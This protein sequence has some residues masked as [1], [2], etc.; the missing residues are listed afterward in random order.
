[1]IIEDP[2]DELYK[3]FNLN[4]SSNSESLS[5]NILDFGADLTGNLDSS[6]A[7][8][9]VIDKCKS[10]NDI[11]DCDDILVK[12]IEI[13][14]GI[15]K[16]NKTIEI[17]HIDNLKFSPII[18]LKDP[19]T[20]STIICDSKNLIFLKINKEALFSKIHIENLI[21]ESIKSIV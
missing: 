3:I 17:N 13:P 2:F 9:A 6:E 15:Y 20:K 19:N 10:I 7:F 16:V 14:S 12:N 5:F 4:E 21:F 11:N 8:Q 18:N 1:M